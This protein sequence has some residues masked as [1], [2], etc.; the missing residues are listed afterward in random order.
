MLRIPFELKPG[1]MLTAPVIR[2]TF[3]EFQIVEHLVNLGRKLALTRGQLEFKDDGRASAAIQR[4][5]AAIA[6]GLV[7]AFG[8]SPS[9]SFIYRLTVA[10]RFSDAIH[11]LQPIVVVFRS[12]RII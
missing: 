3:K 2:A 8:P 10:F 4:R 11:H 5:K 7:V 1:E 9:R 12:Q 6:N